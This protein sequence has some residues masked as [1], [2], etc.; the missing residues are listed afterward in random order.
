MT[1]QK[2]FLEFILNSGDTKDE[3]LQKAIKLAE[4]KVCPVWQLLK[5]N[6]EVITGYKI[7]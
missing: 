6:V 5:N 3:D 7:V 4:E 1:F 2:I